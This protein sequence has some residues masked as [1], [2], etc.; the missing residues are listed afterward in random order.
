[1]IADCP[2]L[3]D[4]A[5]Q[6]LAAQPQ[7]QIVLGGV[8]NPGDMITKEAFFPLNRVLGNN[9]G[10]FVW[11]KQD[12]S[13]SSFNIRLEGTVLHA[14]LRTIAGKLVHSSI[15][16]NDKFYNNSGVLQAQEVPAVV[17]VPQV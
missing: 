11:G 12:F 6:R 16:L 8:G 3:S 2:C 17:A 1:M 4:E 15:D 7:G 5:K 10:S 9:D 14:D 13:A